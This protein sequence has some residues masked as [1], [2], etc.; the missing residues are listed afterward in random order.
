MRWCPGRAGF[1]LAAVLMGLVACDPAGDREATTPPHPA[2]PGTAATV[3]NATTTTPL[4]AA[5]DPDRGFAIDRIIVGGPG[6]GVQASPL[7]R[8]VRFAAG[9]GFD[10]AVFEFET[11]MPYGG[12][13]VGYADG[14]ALGN[15]GC[16][17]PRRRPGADLVLSFHGTGTHEGVYP[18]LGRR[19]YTG[20]E[21][22]RPAS[23]EEIVEAILYCEFEAT[24]EWALVIRDRRPFRAATM[25]DPPRIVVDVEHRP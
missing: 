21:R 7:F 15:A 20:R 19:S 13:S 6:V 3:A 17:A 9:D 4:P 24:V 10:R 12:F 22:I 25:G 11:A 5:V 23:T 14:D 18:D 1:G 16:A 8:Q 2:T